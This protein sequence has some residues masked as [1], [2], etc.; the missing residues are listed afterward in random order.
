MM[1]SAGVPA[2]PSAVTRRSPLMAFVP[3]L[4]FGV[5]AKRA[6]VELGA[7]AGLLAAIA[8][9][10]PSLRARRPKLLELASIVAF[11]VL[12]A[13]ALA[14]DPGQGS[15]LARY[16]RAF[17]AGALAVIAFGSLLF[18]PFTEQYARET[19]PAEVWHTARFRHTNR[20][21]TAVWGGVFAAMALSHVIAGEI[22]TGRANTIGN[23]GIPILLVIG[24][25]RWMDRYRASLP[26]AS[27]AGAAPA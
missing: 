3:W 7:G 12:L 26:P 16:A 27:G 18:V 19:A 2:E 9:S 24:M 23:W 21:F 1:V 15:V 4:V 10:V 22:D 5:V 8:V 6:S 13:V 11:V 20:L 17:A 25:L 14:T